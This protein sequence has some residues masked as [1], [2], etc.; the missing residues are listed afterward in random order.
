LE[1]K[2]ECTDAE[3]TYSIRSLDKG[4]NH[5]KRALRRKKRIYWEGGLEKMYKAMEII[6]TGLRSRYWLPHG[7]EWSKAFC[8]RRVSSGE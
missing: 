8:S 6:V 2:K 5:L 1:L 4:T 7:T 3:R